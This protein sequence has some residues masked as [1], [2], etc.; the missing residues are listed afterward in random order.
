MV[1]VIRDLTGRVVYECSRRRRKSIPNGGTLTTLAHASLNS[2]HPIRKSVGTAAK[3][4]DPLCLLSNDLRQLCSIYGD[5]ERTNQTE[6]EF[7]PRMLLSQQQ[8]EPTADSQE[9]KGLA[10]AFQE[11]LLSRRLMQHCFPSYL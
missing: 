3:E 5:S 8:R 1:V 6:E 9:W 2:R 10:G 4:R 7:R 11:V